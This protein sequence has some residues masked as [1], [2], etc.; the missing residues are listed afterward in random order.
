M[1]T[2]RSRKWKQDEWGRHSVEGSRAC[3][4]SPLLSPGEIRS[5]AAPGMCTRGR[6]EPS[7][8]TIILLNSPALLV[9]SAAGGPVQGPR[10]QP[11]SASTR[12]HPEP[13]GTTR[14]SRSQGGGS[15]DI[16]ELD[17]WHPQPPANASPVSISGEQTQPRR[18]QR[19]ELGREAVV[20]GV[21]LGVLNV[22][23]LLFTFGR[24]SVQS[25]QTLPHSRDERVP[26]SPPD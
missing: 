17:R 7:Q 18:G 15:G 20:G 21:F 1:S 16:S 14:S 4:I 24:R 6:L 9:S 19:V 26:M 10:H 25:A 2:T 8:A 11:R 12:P 13:P 22:L 3:I 23:A 5:P